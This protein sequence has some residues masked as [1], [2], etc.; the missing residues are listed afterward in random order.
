MDWTQAFWVK[1]DNMNELLENLFANRIQYHVPMSRFTASRVG[2]PAE[3]LIVVRNVEELSDAIQKVWE[4]EIPYALIGGGSNV[5]V[6]DDGVDGLVI[7]NRA[8]E[9]RFDLS[10]DKPSVW[11]ES[12]ANFGV[13]SRQ[14][15]SHGLS[16]LEWGVGIPG[17]VGGAV[18][19]NAGA[20]GGDV[21]ESLVLAE[22]LH[23]DGT[24]E[25]W[26]PEKLRY[27]YRSSLL[28]RHPGKSIV[29]SATF[30]LTWSTLGAVQEQV[31][32]FIHYRQKTQPPG[33]SMGSMFKNPVGDY[34]GRLIE[35][36]GLKGTV[37]GDA[38]I[39]DL[40]GNFFV[41]R[42]N[43]SAMDIHRLIELARTKVEEMFGVHLELEIEYIG[44]W[45]KVLDLGR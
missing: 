41:N 26:S 15:A 9:V 6:S 21:S 35:A 24:K 17:T 20:H 36:A 32:E 16:G 3:A 29:L 7:I 4:L 12:G 5:L 39:S 1:S 22:I 11:A 18:V 23:R 43:A 14:A 45:N 42:G 13:I 31:D 38:M 25:T 28:K 10:P 27:R 19:G 8:K 40:H 44:N 37:V 2:G 33:A 34:A 30:G